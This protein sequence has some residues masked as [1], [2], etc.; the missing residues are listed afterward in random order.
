MNANRCPGRGSLTSAR[1]TRRPFM[2][3][4]PAGPAGRRP[5]RSPRRRPAAPAAS[6]G[7]PARPA[8]SPTAGTRCDSRRAVRRKS[9]VSPSTPGRARTGCSRIV[10]RSWN[11]GGVP[12]MAEVLLP[13][14]RVMARD[15]WA[16]RSREIRC[17]TPG[18]PRQWSPWK[19]VMQICEIS[20]AL[21]PASSICRW[22]P[23]PGSNSRPCSVPPQQIA[24]VV[25]VPG[26]RLAR[27]AQD[28]QLPVRHGTACPT[29]T[30]SRGSRGSGRR[31]TQREL[32]PADVPPGAELETDVAEHP[33][34]WK[35]SAS[36]RPTLAGVRQRDAGEERDV[37]EA[38]YLAD[39]LLVQPPAQPRARYR[40]S[41]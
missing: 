31:V 12:Q 39:Q 11:D 37:A 1:C 5:A 38:A 3:S 16:T 15:P 40:G 34:R 32:P 2:S 18:R 25:A 28:H 27:G 20:L 13:L 9:F 35:P 24:I 30:R 29:A 4:R 14:G 21:T 23:S 8:G 6:G 7:R 17:S 19:W 41:R 26:G 36:C 22:V 33:H 10:A